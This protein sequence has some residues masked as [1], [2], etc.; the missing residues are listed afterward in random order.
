[1][2]TISAKIRSIIEVFELARTRN[3]QALRSP[4]KT[5][6]FSQKEEDIDTRIGKNSFK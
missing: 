6:I 5:N 2:Q 3:F 1:M 4:N